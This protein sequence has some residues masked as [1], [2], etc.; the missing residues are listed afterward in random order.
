MNNAAPLL[1]LTAAAALR[2]RERASAL[3]ILAFLCILPGV[4]VA[5]MAQALSRPALIEA[6]RAGGCVLV[7]R[8]AS[9]PAE[10]PA[11][12]QADPGN[13]RRERQ[14][15]ERGRRTAEAMG[16]AMRALR[17]PVGTVLSSPAYRA[18]ETVRL[19]GLG[20]PVP[21]A[22]LGTQAS[23]MARAATDAQRIAW[24]RQRVTQ[25][26]A[27]HTNTLLV[28]HAPNILGA[29]GKQAAGITDGEM[30]VFRPERGR[31]RL[32]GRIRIEEWPGLARLP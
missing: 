20:P 18:L 13:R 12:Q 16:Q 6:L 22:Q 10:P 2:L 15:D 11:P 21:V 7:M 32:L 25:P 19:A 14:L 24:L 3:A 1:Q 31:A 8:H 29:F 27:A 26:P 4:L 17:I 28:T 30:L 23:N 9:S 5:G